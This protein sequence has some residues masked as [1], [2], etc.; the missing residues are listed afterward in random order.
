MLFITVADATLKE[1]ALYWFAPDRIFTA[2]TAEEVPPKKFAPVTESVT[3][4]RLDAADGE[5]V[6]TTGEGPTATVVNVLSPETARFDDM[7]AERT[8]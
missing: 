4:A 2:E 6:D 3:G 7:S 8:R 1:T 5:T